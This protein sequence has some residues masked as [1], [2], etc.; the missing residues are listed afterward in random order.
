MRYL[1]KIYV[2]I[3]IYVFTFTLIS[4]ILNKIIKLF[5]QRRQKVVWKKHSYEKKCYKCKETIKDS[6]L[7]YGLE[8]YI[9]DKCGFNYPC[10]L[11]SNNKHI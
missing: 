7:L 3:C 9:C 8:F 2:Y 5:R 6:N 10:D 4:I 11:F 1:F